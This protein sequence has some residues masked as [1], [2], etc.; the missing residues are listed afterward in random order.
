[1]LFENTYFL[2]FL[3]TVFAIYL[4]DKYYT[5]KNDKEGNLYQE[6]KKRYEKES[7]YF[8][9]YTEFIFK[10]HGNVNN[11]EHLG[12][13]DDFVKFLDEMFFYFRIFCLIFVIL[14]ALFFL[15]KI[16]SNLIHKLLKPKQNLHVLPPGKYQTTNSANEWLDSFELYLDEAKIKSDT[17]KCG[18]FLSRMEGTVKN[19][20]KN[21]D[22]NVAKDYSK[23]REAFVRIYAKKKKTYQEY[24]AD[25]LSC[26]QDGMNLFH[27][28]AELCRL[29]RKA[30]PNLTESQKVEQIHERFIT[31]LNNDLLRGHLLA[32]F[33]NDGLCTRVFGSKSLIE[34]AVELEEIYGTKQVE[35][36]FVK[37]DTSNVTCHACKNKGHYAFQCPT[38]PRQSGGN[39][40]GNGT[41]PKQN[42]QSNTAN[43]QSNTASSNQN[44][45]GLNM[46]KLNKVQYTSSITGHCKLD[47]K[48][49][50]FMFDTGASKTVI[51]IK[52]L[53]N[54][55]RN[56]ITPSPYH[57]ILA[58]GTRTEV[59]GVKKCTIQIG[60]CAMELDVLVTKNLHEG[61]LLGIDFLSQ[62]PMTKD[63][64]E[65]LRDAAN[66]GNESH[67]NNVHDVY[68]CLIS[69]KME[70]SQ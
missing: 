1:M 5:I 51:D 46:F 34:R 32:S 42:G 67:V 61:C 52:L 48:S 47:G 63:L 65:Q 7:G 10:K 31:G 6:W 38:N 49:T 40:N 59:E 36:N 13:K 26:N 19:T 11:R 21:Y 33:K 39:T 18:A 2:L 41:R 58:D 12:L 35:I 3:E 29:A 54:E 37:K 22:R 17:E 28:H 43:N 14:L 45:H 23:L 70:P 25:F 30:F 9:R 24:N 68:V 69:T 8:S 27:Y 16:L 4:L 55:Q 53:S 15:L 56:N 62:C 20:L 50:N 64:I 44:Q 57:V 60:N 66:E